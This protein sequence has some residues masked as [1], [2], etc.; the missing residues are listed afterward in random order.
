MAK[1]DSSKPD[2]TPKVTAELRTVEQWAEVRGW[3]PAF[4]Q[5][6][7]P[8]RPAY[9]G[10]RINVAAP[11][12]NPEYGR[13]AGARAYWNWPIGREMT[14]ADFEAAVIEAHSHPIR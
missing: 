10:G 5:P 8:K 6:P 3:L 2:E 4:F 14:E 9:A 11:R 13:F 1:T 12:P 7:K